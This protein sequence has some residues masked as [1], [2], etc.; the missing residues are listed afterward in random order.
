MKKFI[1]NRQLPKVIADEVKK[2]VQEALQHSDLVPSIGDKDPQK[3]I[4][5]LTFALEKVHDYLEY[6]NADDMASFV[7][8]VL[9]GKHPK[10]VSV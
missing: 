7:K 6:E 10:D 4:D 9:K 5:R 1:P 8:Q 3:E 2:I